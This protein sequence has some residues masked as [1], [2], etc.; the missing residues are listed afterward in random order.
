MY[1]PLPLFVKAEWACRAFRGH[2]GRRKGPHQMSTTWQV[3]HP[4]A[5]RICV[6]LQKALSVRGCRCP[7]Y[8]VRVA[9]GSAG[10]RVMPV[11]E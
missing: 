8:R 11:I 5:G 10:Q 3:A 1:E 4:S 2:A 6:S 9:D 7:P